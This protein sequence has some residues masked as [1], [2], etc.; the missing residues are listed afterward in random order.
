IT[1]ASGVTISQTP[2]NANTGKPGDGRYIVLS[3]NVANPSITLSSGGGGSTSG[4]WSLSGVI[5][6]PTGSVTISNKSALEDSGQIIVNSWNDQSGY[7]Q[8]PSVSFNASFAPQQ[9]EVLQLSE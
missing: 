8:N 2:F 4:I 7:H 6:L 1:V 9:Q 3:D 5:W